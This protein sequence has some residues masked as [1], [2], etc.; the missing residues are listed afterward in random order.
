MKKAVLTS[1][2][3]LGA[4]LAILIAVVVVRTARFGSQSATPMGVQQAGAVT[5]NVDSA[6]AIARLQN[7][8][9]IPTVSYFDSPPRL[10]Q[11]AKLHAQLQR[12]F[13]LVHARLTR[14]VLDSGT[15]LFTWRGTDTS[16]APALIMG[17][18]DVVPVEP[19][20]E[21]NWTHAP[22]S[23]D[24]AD[25]FVWGR[26]TLDDKL[27]VLGTLEGAENL[28]KRGVQ[29]R[30]T[31]I[32]AFGFTEEVGGPS[33]AH[34]VDVLESRGVR[35]WFVMDEGGAL[36]SGL[37]P[38]VEK[39]VA[40][41][42]TAEKGYLTLRLT[43]KAEGGHSSMPARENAVTI[44]ANAVSRLQ[45]EP[46]RAHLSDASKAMFSRIGPLMPFSRRMVF[47]N[48]W[49]FEP[50]LLRELSK[51]PGGNAVARTTTAVTMLNAGIKDNV[52]PSTAGAVVNFRLAPG[53][54]SAWVISE[55]KRII[56]DARVSVEPMANQVR[57]ASA[58]SPDTSSGFRLIASTVG[59][60]WPGTNVSPYLVMG[61]TDS[62]QY[63]AITPNVYRFAPIVAGTETMSLLHGTNER[64]GVGNY[65][66]AVRFYTR[67]LESAGK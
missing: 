43:A 51:Q 14:E 42:G 63:Y 26:G 35:P 11:F 52:I 32:L 22:F 29:P 28:L 19:G 54:S 10:A 44:L 47:A 20:T 4:I 37:V 55:V 60:I 67:L 39:P 9:R 38:G 1:A 53:D 61:G 45:A 12:D 46:L 5:V 65:V 21:Q 64:I 49:L 57:E 16:L 24:V 56:A 50:L 6:G 59:E 27:S 34:T 7:A 36:G 30:R 18:Q 40:L 31:I 23:G 48:L 62:R 17:H 58:V 13:P 66:G 25:G 41:I 33:V 3:G 2:L 8:I 15:L